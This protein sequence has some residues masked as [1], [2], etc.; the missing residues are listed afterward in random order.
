M[1]QELDISP[2]LHVCIHA[3]THPENNNVSANF[4]IECRGILLAVVLLR[5]C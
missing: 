1:V 5:S 2:I 4:N 3:N